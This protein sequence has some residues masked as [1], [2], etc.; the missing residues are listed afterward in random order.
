[1]RKYINDQY[2]FHKKISPR[3]YFKYSY[4]WLNSLN[5]SYQEL[6]PCVQFLY[7]HHLFE[8]EEENFKRIVNDLQRHFVIISY[9]EA[10]NR[11]QQN[12]IDKNYLCFSF[13][14]GIRNTLRIADYF[15]EMNISAMFFVNPGIVEN[16]GNRSFTSAHCK[17]KLHL[18][19]LDF[20]NWEDLE[21]LINKGHEIG[22]H[23]FS[24]LNL[25][26]VKVPEIIDKEIIYSKD[27]LEEK[28][29][30]VKHFSWP[31]GRSIHINDL[32]IQKIKAAG[33]SS[34]ASAIRGQHFDNDNKPYIF[35]DHVMFK[36]PA[37][38]LRYFITRN[39]IR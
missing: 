25:A 9:T 31:Y 39:N 12:S 17:E 15:S 32:L 22:N 21:D 6:K 5:S 20:M 23:S 24:H 7:G 29:G 37:F 4:I 30:R 16:A 35:R 34:V 26:E 2:H 28:I 36:E 19:D 11:I 33:H 38:Y 10:V 3:E 13:D 18:M 14:D 8:D 1:M 27:L